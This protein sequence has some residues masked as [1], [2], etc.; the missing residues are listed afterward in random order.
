M[1]KRALE[2][3]CCNANNLGNFALYLAEVRQD[4]DEA[5]KLY[6]CQ[7]TGHRAHCPRSAV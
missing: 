2:A 7:S 4:Y 3:D 5:K 1:Y 6:V